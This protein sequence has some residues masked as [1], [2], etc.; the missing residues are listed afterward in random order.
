MPDPQAD[1]QEVLAALAAV[2]AGPDDGFDLAGTALLLATLTR[3]QVGLERYRAHLDDLAA[4][5]RACVTD[6]PGSVTEAAAALVETITKRFG[7]G[8]DR[9]T[10]EDLQNANLIRVIDRRKGLPVA[11][12]ILYMHAARAQ[13]WPVSG[14]KFPG[15]FLIR[16]EVSGERAILDPFNDGQPCGPATLRA[17][18]KATHGD[19]AELTPDHY[20]TVSDREILLRLQNNVKL[21]LIQTGRADEAAQVVEAMLAFAPAHAPLWREAGLLHAHLGN[22]QAAVDALERYLAQEPGG[23]QR[24]DAVA[25]LQKLRRQLN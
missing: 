11:L 18:L 15:H 16:L 5:L 21:R 14:L 9:Q 8:G 24:Q 1:R 20:D 6:P 17:L 23:R 3:P 10:Y 22:L 13:G 2:G 7:Y 25:L 19:A 4:D 12:G